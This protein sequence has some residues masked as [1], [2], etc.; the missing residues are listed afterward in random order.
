M[1]RVDMGAT[2]S[3]GNASW[4]KKKKGA[5]SGRPSRKKEKELLG[6]CGGHVDAGQLE[7]LALYRALNGH[8]M[9]GMSCHLVLR[10][11]NVHFLVRVVY[12]HVLGAVLLDALGRALAGLVVCALD[13]A[14]AV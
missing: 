9:A 12:E 3:Y 8:V 5:L 1:R 14:L 11:D 4:R 7:G 2:T 13:P 6:C 10:V